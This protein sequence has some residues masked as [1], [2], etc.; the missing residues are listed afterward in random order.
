MS[1]TKTYCFGRYLADIPV[2]AQVNGYASRY[3]YGYI[4]SSSLSRVEFDEYVGKREAVIRSGKQK[5]GYSLKGGGRISESIWI[6]ELENQLL[7]GLSVGFE[8]HRWDG[9]RAFEMTQVGTMSDKYD[10]VLSTMKTSVLPNLHARDADDIPSQPG[11]CLKDGFIDD[12]GTTEQYEDSGMSFKFPQWPGILITV[13]ASTTTKAG[14]KTL[15]QR[16]GSAWLPTNFILV[17][18]LRRGKRTVNGRD[19]EEI[20]WSFPTNH[21][22]RSHQFQ[23]EAQGT[24]SQP[25]NADLTVEFESGLQAKGGEWQRPNLSDE[26]AIAIFDAVVK[27]IRL[28][29]TSDAKASRAAPPPTMPLGTLVQTGSACPQTGWWTCPEA[30]GN[31]LAGGGRRYFVAGSPM[32]VATILRGRTLADRLFGKPARYDVPTTWRLV[33]SDPANDADTTP[34][35]MIR[36]D[37]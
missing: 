31:E 5:D 33:G 9:G 22:F 16:V 28:R 15:L 10:E 14:E 7:T 25:L 13:S 34:A 21:G 35:S 1:E 29:P 3:K 36:T 6:F 26:E 2:G 20:L 4:K 30:N 24:L 12:D 19:G 17:K 11:F 18:T 27:S 37:E 32:P 23:W 8:A